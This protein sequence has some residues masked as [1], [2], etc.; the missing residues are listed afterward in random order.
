MNDAWILPFLRRQ[1]R[2]AHADG[3]CT[4]L[5]LFHLSGSGQRGVQTWPVPEEGVGDSDLEKW[6]E[7]MLTRAQEDANEIFGVQRYVICAY[8]ARR[9]DQVAESRPFQRNGGGNNFAAGFEGEGDPDSEPAN[10][11]GLLTQLMRHNEANVRSVV[12]SSQQLLR[13]QGHMITVLADR[14]GD[15]EQ[16]HTEYVRLT[17]SLLSERHLREL[18]T[19]ESE[20]KV[21]AWGEGLEKLHLLAPVV[22]NKLAGQRILP[23]QTTVVGEMVGSLVESLTNDQIEKLSA[24]L[25]PEQLI[26]VLNLV[27]E[28]RALTARVRAEQEAQ[29]KAMAPA[30]GSTTAGSP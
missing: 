7:T 26:V 3:A 19:K 4:R 21:R 10:A 24:V 17:E 23:E 27:E 13:A 28:R 16:R 8:Y 2:E 11:K 29:Q 6:A 15:M 20:L 1:L 12:Q 25:K 22:I 9:P 14:Q 30:N 18:A 5:S